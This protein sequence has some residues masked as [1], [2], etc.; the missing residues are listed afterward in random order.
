MRRRQIIRLAGVSA[1]SLSG[2]L[3]RMSSRADGE[4]TPTTDPQTGRSTPSESS[5]RQLT[6]GETATF[7]DGTT[8]TVTDPTVQGSAIADIGGRF[9]SVVREQDHQIV[10]I[11]V[12]GDT[13]VTPSEFRVQRDGQTSAPPTKRRYVRPVTRSCSGTCIGVPITTEATDSAAVV[14]KPDAQTH[15]TWDLSADTV[16][17]FS[18]Q[19]QCELREARLTGRDGETAV[20]LTVE[21]TGDRTAG[22]RALVAPAWVSDVSDPIG[23]SVP[24]AETVTETVVPPEL[25]GINPETATFTREVTEETRYIEVGST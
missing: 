9:L 23:F 24:E 13:D 4:T 16:A 7:P 22:F 3:G 14:Y 20:R 8:L 6:V 10:V 21:N 18:T 17:L 25:G 19:P 15:T 11:S 5:P 1:V 12:E 2:C